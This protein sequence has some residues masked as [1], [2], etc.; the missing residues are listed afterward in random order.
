MNKVVYSIAYN[1]EGGISSL[2]GWFLQSNGSYLNE[3]GRTIRRPNGDETY[4]EKT[5]FGAITYRIIQ[6]GRAPHFSYAG[7]LI[8]ELIN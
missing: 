5:P 8:W 4:S 2:S 1:S 3:N 6:D 7:E